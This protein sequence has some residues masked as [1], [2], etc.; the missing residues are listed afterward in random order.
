MICHVL[1][2]DHSGNSREA[3]TAERLPRRATCT[4]EAASD[5][6]TCHLERRPIVGCDGPP[7]APNVPRPVGQP[8]VTTAHVD[9][10]TLTQLRRKCPMLRVVVAQ[11]LQVFGTTSSGTKPACRTWIPT[12]AW[13]AGLAAPATLPEAST[14]PAAR[15]TAST[16]WTKRLVATPVRARLEPSAEG[17]Q[18]RAGSRW[19]AS[20]VAGIPTSA[21]SSGV[22]GRYSKRGGTTPPTRSSSERRIA[23]AG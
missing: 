2:I 12:Q 16:A 5:M 20:G 8:R 13:F 19:E 22:R 1:I 15:P 10:R 9:A 6:S 11:S 4:S 23:S 14:T 7:R 17:R 21:R 3:A 18:V